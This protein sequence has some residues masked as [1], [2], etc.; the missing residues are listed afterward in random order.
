MAALRSG[1]SPGRSSTA[2]AEA[3]L[4]GANVA[5]V[6][7]GDDEPGGRSSPQIPVWPATSPV[8]PATLPPRG[9]APPRTDP[10]SGEE[11]F[12]PRTDRSGAPSGM[13]GS[14]RTLSFATPPT[15]FAVDVIGR[16]SWLRRRLN[17]IRT[18]AMPRA[19]RRTNAPS[20]VSRSERPPDMNSPTRPPPAP[21]RSGRVSLAGCT[22]DAAPSRPT[23][24]MTTP[25]QR[26][27]PARARRLAR[28]PLDVPARREQQERQEPAQAAEPRPDGLLEPAW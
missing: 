18:P 26:Q 22:I 16:R 11:P 14:R 12:P 8:V 17:A 27:A 15:H 1:G 6:G 10:A 20:G 7:A 5:D 19:M 28:A 3:L 25:E 13:P 9:R 4:G 2:V 24:A 21:G 23:Y